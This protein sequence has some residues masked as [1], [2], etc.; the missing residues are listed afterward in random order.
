MIDHKTR[1]KFLN[2]ISITDDELLEKIIKWVGYYLSPED[3]FDIDQLMTWAEANYE[4][5]KDD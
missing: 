1:I 5:N 4:E 3:V 2:D